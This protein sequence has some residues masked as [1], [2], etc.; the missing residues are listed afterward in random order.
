[1]TPLPPRQLS[2]DFLTKTRLPLAEWHLGG[3]FRFDFYVQNLLNFLQKQ[4][5]GLFRIASVS[6]APA[7][8]WSIDWYR[9]RPLEN[10][11]AYRKALEDYALAG[12]GVTVEFDNPVVS[13]E[14]LRDAA[15]NQLL[16]E[17]YQR[18]RI[19]K[20]AVSV[21]N[22]RLARYIRAEFPKLPLIAHLNRAV[23]EPG[24]RT[25]GFYNRLAQ[26]YDWVTLHPV[27]CDR[28]EVIGNLESPGRF[29]AVVND[30]CL[31]NCPVRREHMT[32]LS[33]L[34]RKPYAAELSG[35]RARFLQTAGCEAIDAAVLRQKKTLLLSEETL[36]ALAEGGIT[37]FAVQDASLRNEVS[38][39]WELLRAL[40]GPASAQGHKIGCLVSSFLAGCVPSKNKLPSGL[41]TFEFGNYD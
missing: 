24:K 38:V 34:R 27:D 30:S 33:Q 12:T 7:C 15:A 21:A 31:R 18:D 41:R 36:H 28:P 19:R 39:L 3:A 5:P 26:Q 13:D 11:A 4:M 16:R 2:L 14:D 32:L 1:M 10:L 23:M 37:H 17:L 9:P 40:F 20:N 35:G 8:L 25:A 6:G 22:D 29:I